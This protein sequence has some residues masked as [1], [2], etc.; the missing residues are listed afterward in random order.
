MKNIHCSNRGSIFLFI[1][2]LSAWILVSTAYA[3]TPSGAIPP[4][5][6]ALITV[7]G[8]IVDTRNLPIGNATITITQKRGANGEQS[9]QVLPT[10]SDGRF[11]ARVQKGYVD[12]IV[13]K[14][15]GYKEIKDIAVQLYGM[16]PLEKTLQAESIGTCC[17]LLI[18]VPGILGLLI[19]LLTSESRIQLGA[20]TGSFKKRIFVAF[21]N[22]SVWAVVLAAIWFKMNEK[23]INT[24]QLFHPALT[25]EFYIPL[26]GLF[27]SLLFVFD[28]FLNPRD[29][30]KGKEFGMRIIMAPYIAIVMVLIFGNDFTMLGS[31]TG[32]ATLAFISGLL[33]VVV[34]Q[35]IIERAN[36][37]LGNWR[38]KSEN[39]QSPIAQRF[40]LNEDEEKR[41]S[42]MHI[43]HPGQLLEIKDEKLME[44]AKQNGIDSSLLM[45]IKKHL[46]LEA[47]REAIGEY[48]WQRLEKAK[49]Q[50]IAD[51]SR[52]ADDALKKIAGEEPKL[53]EAELLN[54]RNQARNF[55]NRFSADIFPESA[56][57]PISEM[58]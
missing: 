41:L 55:I 47:F 46:Q 12:S 35:G 40:N 44:K 49:I 16:F 7:S 24:I 1:M 42:L 53:A 39:Q 3:N 52:L 54:L 30:F 2:V 9:E 45:N 34:L 58:P 33:V 10:S 21:L 51:F 11:H 22:G 13:Y 26:L 20:S 17:N 57:P 31:H 27:G 4:S 6:E 28:L 18:L 8:R 15:E 5:S 56:S 23:G 19:P 36:S 37:M 38:R 48:I 25:F 50:S 14:A 43:R 29:K 32:R